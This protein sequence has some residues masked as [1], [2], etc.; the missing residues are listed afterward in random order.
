M[1][2]VNA[3]KTAINL[4]VGNGCNNCKYS[5]HFISLCNC[6]TRTIIDQNNSCTKIVA[7]GISR[8]ERGTCE[9]YEHS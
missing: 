8:D 1:E 7:N 5:G 6:G 3:G 9:Y 2:V 4:L